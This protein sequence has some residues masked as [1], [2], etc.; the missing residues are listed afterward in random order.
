[1]SVTLPP[2]RP[3]PRL[4]VLVALLISLTLSACVAQPSGSP[5]APTPS[6]PSPEPSA[7]ATAGPTSSPTAPVSPAPC[8]P[9]ALAVRLTGWTGAAGHRIGTVELRNT[10]AVPCTVAELARPQLVDGRGTVLIDGAPP[11]ASQELTVESGGTL[12][13]MVQDSSYC[14]ANP[15]P[16]VTVAFVLP[17][18]GQVLAAPLS[19]TDTSG[20]PPCLGPDGSAGSIEM[21]S[22]TP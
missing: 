11:P 21:Q 16:P 15:L 7:T 2:R 5:S 19:A 18:G 13:T 22:W 14:G 3:M 4:G 17:G 10:G 12:T 6:S 9:A 20:V 8:G 1:M